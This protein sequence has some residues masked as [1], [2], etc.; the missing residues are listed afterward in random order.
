MKKKNIVKIL[1]VILLITIS[2]FG[3]IKYKKSY[4]K[5]LVETS[6]SD[7]GS[8]ILNIYMIGEADFPYGKTHCRFNLT[9]YSIDISEVSFDISDDGAN[10]TEDNFN[11]TWNDEYVSIIVSGSEQENVT[12]NL[13]F[14]GTTEILG[15]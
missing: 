15:E 4:S 3:Y 8:Y 9:R 6:L 2:I 14:D 10:A 12:Y 11:I 7:D 5:N 1:L 13:Y